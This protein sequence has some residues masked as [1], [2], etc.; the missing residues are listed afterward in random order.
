M[1]ELRRDITTGE[2]VIMNTGRRDRPSDLHTDENSPGKPAAS[3]PCP[4]CAGQEHL[5]PPQILALDGPEKG[6]WQVRVVPNLFPAVTLEE[7]SAGKIENH[8]F[9]SLPGVG[10]HEV[11]IETPEHHQILPLM[12]DKSIALV[13]QAYRERYLALSQVPALKTII[14]F[15]NHGRKAGTS[16]EHPHSQIVATAVI[17]GYIRRQCDLA[18][19]YY[20]QCNSNMYTDLIAAEVQARTRIIIETGKYVVFHPFASQRPFE[21]WIIRREFQASFSQVSP[22]EIGELASVLRQTLLKLYRGLKNPDYN[23]VIY[24]V[25]VGEE[26][27]GFYQWHIRIIPRITE[28]AGFEI[29]SGIFINTA[30]PEETAK[31]LRELKA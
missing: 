27:S 28:A 12:D 29:G 5:T 4:F 9:L 23:L 18:A 1:S 25:P 22:E 31:F 17:P 8:L 19:N 3:T 2:W 30:L 11:I 10:K 6:R 7:D 14:I 13:L 21:T 16:L 26:Q 15:K 20:R 24:S